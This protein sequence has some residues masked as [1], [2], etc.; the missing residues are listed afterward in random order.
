MLCLVVSHTRD[1][2]GNVLSIYENG[3][4]KKNIY[5]FNAQNELIGFTNANGD[6][7]F[8]WHIKGK[9]I[10]E[11]HRIFVCIVKIEQDYG[12][13]NDRIQLTDITDEN[14]ITQTEVPIYGSDRI[15]TYNPQEETNIK[16]DIYILNRSYKRYELK[17][18]LGNVRVTVSDSKRVSF[19]SETLVFSADIKTYTDYYAFGMEM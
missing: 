18:H 2:Q 17:D 9:L 8:Q 4:Q 1:A 15:G 12:N 16:S 13:C 11:G 10:F 3:K 19:V 6:N 7:L 14:L 5:Y